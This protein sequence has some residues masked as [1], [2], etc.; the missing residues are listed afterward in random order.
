MATTFG[1]INQKGGVGKTSLALHMAAWLRLQFPDK[2]TMLLDC[3]PQG[4]AQMWAAARG[5]EPLFPIFGKATETVHK[6]FDSL[7]AGYD[8][9][10]IDGPANVSKIN[11]SAIMCCDVVVVPTEPAAF[12]IW[13]SAA[14]LDV[15]DGVQGVSER[16]T[17][18]LINKN[19][20]T[21]ISADSTAALRA[22]PVPTLESVINRRVLW[23]AAVASGTTIFELDKSSDAVAEAHAAFAELMEFAK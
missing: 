17:T 22:Q 2:K 21:N 8:Y 16:K 23:K 10:V 3:D 7:V 18:F 6:Q 1:F 9:V 20:A 4:N 11:G 5:E 14:I 15:I 13:A 12:D 19:D